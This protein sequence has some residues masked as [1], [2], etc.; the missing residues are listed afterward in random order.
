MAGEASEVR[1]VSDSEGSQSRIRWVY[2]LAAS[3]LFALSCYLHERYFDFFVSGVTGPFSGRRLFVVDKFRWMQLLEQAGVQL[4][5]LFWSH[6]LPGALLIFALVLASRASLGARDEITLSPRWMWAATLAVGGI[7]LYA[8]EAFRRFPVTVD[9]FSQVFESRVL[10]LG[11]GWSTVA[12]GP[13]DYLVSPF[14]KDNPWMGSYPPGWSA[15]LA[16]LPDHLVWLG[17][18]L[19]STLGIPVLYWFSRGFVERKEAVWGVFFVACS[20]GY[21][22]QGATYFPHHAH[23]AV[24]ALACALYL[25][26]ERMQ[27]LWMALLSGL[28]GAWA[29]LV[30]PIET[31]LFLAVCALWIVV[32]RKRIAVSK[33]LLG[34]AL[35]GLLVGSVVYGSFQLHL[36]SFYLELNRELPHHFAAG[37]WNFFYPL[38]RNIAWWSPFYCLSVLYC[39][40]FGRMSPSLWLLVMHGIATMLAF[41]V[42]IDNGQVEYGSRYLFTAWA[43]LAPLVGRGWCG[44]LSRFPSL[45][46]SVVALGL[47]LYA[48][49]PLGGLWEE[50]QGRVSWPLVAAQAQYPANGVFFVRQTPNGN[51]TELIRNFPNHGQ[52]WVYFLEPERN[53]ALRKHWGDRPAYVVDW[54]PDGL[55]FTR[56][57]ECEMDDSFSRM[58]AANN[59]SVFLGRRLRG[60]DLWLGIPASDPY[61]GAARLNAGLAYLKLG[62]S[63]KGMELLE[64]ARNAGIP[65]HIVDALLEQ[66]RVGR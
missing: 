45:S 62:E 39:L 1:L 17:P 15:A 21:F 53:R 64:T 58:L 55:R 22:W 40:K 4:G 35:A 38:V 51:P 18:I 19:V 30:R 47:A 11:K 20:A 13:V 8:Q 42:F 23:L 50:A 10:R 16:L 44:V 43:M 26:A 27:R 5:H 9:E 65:S 3:S 52:N 24:L 49:G 25:R 31:A 34:I 28:A 66:N 61:F 56:F 33:P 41:A 32:F 14:V 12:Q 6:L 60:I 37:V 2:A 36:G 57:E 46:P 59:L 54:L 7:G 48:C 63:E 29:V